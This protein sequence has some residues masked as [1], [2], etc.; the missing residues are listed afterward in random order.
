MLPIMAVSRINH[1]AV[2]LLPQWSNTGESHAY[3]RFQRNRIDRTTGGAIALHDP[4][5][6]VHG[7]LERGGHDHRL[8]RAAFYRAAIPEQPRRPGNGSRWADGE[9]CTLPVYRGTRPRRIE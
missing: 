2:N 8:P 7:V 9:L 5:F 1:T 6:A 3:K 4:V